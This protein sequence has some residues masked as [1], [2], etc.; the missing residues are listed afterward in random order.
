MPIATF[1]VRALREQRGLSRKRLADLSGLTESRVWGA[2]NGKQLA[3]EH[4]EAISHVLLPE[5][6]IDPDSPNPIFE[7]SRAY[8]G[9]IALLPAVIPDSIPDEGSLDLPILTLV[10]QL[11]TH[12]EA[13]SVE[14]LSIPT[15]GG[16]PERREGVRLISNS[17]IMTFKQ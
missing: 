2:E 9:L 7:A 10:E 1:D 14:P 8:T 6:Q 3:A 17:E 4:V 11:P 13:Q 15:A 5:P 12:P 16:G